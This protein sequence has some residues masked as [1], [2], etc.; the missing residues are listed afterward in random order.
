[1]S[2]RSLA[3]P[4]VM[5]LGLISI[6]PSGAEDAPN[7]PLPLRQVVL[8]SSGVGYFQRSGTI[9][10]TA[11]V[12]LSF[13]TEKINDIL[14]SLVLI[15]PQGG[16][17]TVAYPTQAS[18][19]RRLRKS[20]QALNAGISLGSLLSQFQG[21]QVRLTQAGGTAVEGRIISVNIK[22]IPVKDAGV[23]QADV[24]NLLTGSGLRAIP[25]DQVSEVT[26]L[27]ERLERELRESLELLATGLDDQRQSIQLQFTGNGAR[28]V[29]AGYLQE[30]PVWKTSY[31][32][33]LDKAE[34]P[35]L[36][37]WAIVE[38][39]TDEDWKD[40]RLSLVSGRPVSFIQDLYQPLY[41]PR[42]TV[43]PQV[44]GSPQPQAY[45][46]AVNGSLG[47]G[48]G[49]FGG[50]LGLA[51]QG[52]DGIGGSPLDS[53]LQMR[54]EPKISM[55]LR[56]VPL[57]E[58]VRRVLESSGQQYSINPDVPDVP[59]TLNLREISPQAAIRLMVRQAAATA[60][61]LTFSKD[62]D[63]LVVKI[64][65][66][67]P[68]PTAQEATPEFADNGVDLLKRSINAAALAQG[69]DRGALFSY[70]IRQPVS[71]A[72]Q[73]AVMVPIVSAAVSGEA[74]SIF[75]PS[76]DTQHALNGFLLK[77]TT[78]LHLSGGPITVFRDGAY[79]GDSQILH[80]QP[81]EDRLLS[82]AVD[83]DLIAD[84][85]EPHFSNETV[86]VSAKAGVL[87]IT[88][89]QQREAV[90]KFRNKSDQAKTL[91]IQQPVMDG[92]KLKVP[93]KASEETPEEYRFR[94]TVPPGK[95]G[96]LKVVTVH[97]LSQV[98]MLADMNVD[99]LTGYA[100]NAEVPEQLR[101]ALK[102]LLV[103]RRKATDLQS[104]RA[105]L[106][107]ELKGIDQDQARIRQN[108]AALDRNSPLYQTYVKKLTEQETRIEKLRS[109]ITRL[110][111]AEKAGLRE[112]RTFL[113]GL[114]VDA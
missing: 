29:K 38:N 102:Q 81:K 18:I 114:T 69:A 91:I 85:E 62:G 41:V 44:V 113:D 70:D 22:S 111:E 96:E 112:M 83:L 76:S 51:H 110:Q 35:Y 36:Q 43:A 61:G 14:K 60:P 19:A 20:G 1:M 46:E 92:W 58:A 11:A 53:S 17:R 93:E 56:A 84:W 87:Q 67:T 23:A 2:P 28:E 34:K 7:Q 105:A 54:P 25:L 90:Y 68:G 4:L 106:E 72:R 16:A 88:R 45:L 73:Q 98:F 30:M 95:N 8:Y 94:L 50:G 63:I 77:N 48:M 99:T 101:A 109:E 89:K 78:G 49:G 21:A 15:D 86:A 26:L 47:G 24:L 71:V 13:R 59:I 64:R 9:A 97:P 5:G 52:V 55:Q 65:R 100:Q 74:V 32:L 31:R 33:V 37:G 40:V 108:L 27:D 42:P 107:T 39:T 103:L 75:D 10:G 12:D 79:A 3:V 57:R 80:L 82:Y 66:N 6:L 104:Q